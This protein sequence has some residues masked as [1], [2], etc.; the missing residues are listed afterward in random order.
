VHRL[1]MDDWF[2]SISSTSELPEYVAQEL[3]DIGF[4]VIPGPVADERLDQVADAYDSAISCATPDDLS[5]GSTTTRVHDFVNRGPD[6]D[7]LYIY[8]PILGAC[9]RII[10]RPFKLSTML[11]RTV[12]PN[13]EAQ[14]RMWISGARSMDG[15]WSA[16]LSW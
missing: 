6:F 7:E 15:R 13:S 1:S 3:N 14:E 10:G 9:C 2:S 12:N 8:R 16:S 11:A 4:V 5:I